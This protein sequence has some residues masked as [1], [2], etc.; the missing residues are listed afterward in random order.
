ML[1]AAEMTKAIAESPLS[2]EEKIRWHFAVFSKVT[3]SDDDIPLFWAAIHLAKI[4]GDMNTILP[5]PKGKT[6]YGLPYTTAGTVLKL[7]RLEAYV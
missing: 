6:A 4:G 1:S 3:I 2:I 5:M 7:F